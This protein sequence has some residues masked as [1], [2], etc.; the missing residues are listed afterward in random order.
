MLDTWISPDDEEGARAALPP[1][2]TCAGDCWLDLVCT[3]HL[4]FLQHFS[5]G[6][7]ISGMRCT[8]TSDLMYVWSRW[9]C[10]FSVASAW[11]WRMSR[12]LVASLRW[13]LQPWEAGFHSEFPFN[14]SW[15]QLPACSLSGALHFPYI[16]T[17]QQCCYHCT[18]QPL[19]RLARMWSSW[20]RVCFSKNTPIQWSWKRRGHAG[21]GISWA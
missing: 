20:K 1:A 9:L 2:P 16:S 4:R 3:K 11:S 19:G 8:H 21:A 13:A 7:T 12:L 14:S 5:L 6:G 18:G 15:L 17:A 10:Q